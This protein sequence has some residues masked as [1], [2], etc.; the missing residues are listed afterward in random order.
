[1]A[2]LMEESFDGGALVFCTTDIDACNS[3]HAGLAFSAAD[4]SISSSSSS[5][6]LRC[7]SASAAGC[8]LLLAVPSLFCLASFSGSCLHA[9]LGCAS[10]V[11]LCLPACQTSSCQSVILSSSKGTV[12]HQYSQL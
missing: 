10:S 3:L 12:T 5:A 2:L 1:M 4:S 8:S 9:L 6:R 7:T 11:L